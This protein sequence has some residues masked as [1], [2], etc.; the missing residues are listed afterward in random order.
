MALNARQFNKFY[1]ALSALV[2]V[3]VLLRCA[4]VPFA[5]DEVATFNYYIQSGRFIPFY[6]HVDAM[7]HFLLSGS[8]WVAFKLFGSSTLALRLPVLLSF[9]VLSVAV[10]KINNLLSGTFPKILLTFSFI[11]SFHFISFF[12]LCRGYGLSMAFL[13]FAV[14]YFY[15]YA[16]H[17]SFRHLFKFVFFSQLALSANLTLVFVLLITTGILMLLQLK[18]KMFFK[19]K[20]LLLLLLHFGLIA[21]W[22][23]FAFYLQE[24]GALYY[25]VGSNYWEV[26][27]KTLLETIALKSDVV[28]VAALLL[29][30]FMFVYL[31]VK[32]RKESFDALLSNNFVLSISTF[33][34]LVLA[35]YLLKKLFNVNYPEDRTGLFFYVF[36]MLALCFM[37]NEFNSKLKYVFCLLPL[38]FATQFVLKANIRVHPWAIYETIPESFFTTLVN[39]QKKS[40]KPIT[41]GG[42]RMREFIFTFLNYNSTDKLNY[43]T[44]PEALQMNCD[45]AIAYKQDKPYYEPY[46]TELAQ[47]NDWGF[48]LI[49]RKQAIQKKQLYAAPAPLHFTGKYEYYNVCE[50]FDT[51][52]A[53]INPLQ[54]DLELSFK[55]VPVRLNAWLVLQIESSTEGE[56]GIFTRIPLNLVKFDWNGTQHYKMALVS[57]NVPKRIKRLVCYLWNINTEE[58]DIDVNAFTLSQLHG[59]GVTQQSKLN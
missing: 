9:I 48:T 23:K 49:K 41:I 4:F 1:W 43:L 11:F 10:F 36:F 33:A 37:V 54:A 21:F 26:T 52:Y 7:G 58:I 47:E 6:S 16:K 19:W 13:L 3:L 8:A 32:V 39:E 46:Y 50:F 5:H 24:N 40:S 53:L 57:G 59:E 17:F 38:F 35:F 42:H 18:H 51:T 30:G 27:F 56:E 45:Y 15:C 29:L 31:S 25:G 28:N 22:V 44:A 12:S 55:K 2:F 14:F 20:N 34:L